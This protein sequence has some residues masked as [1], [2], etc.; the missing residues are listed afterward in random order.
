MLGHLG[1]GHGRD[2]DVLVLP[3]GALLVIL[4]LVITQGHFAG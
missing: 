1:R 4:I 3:I 2:F